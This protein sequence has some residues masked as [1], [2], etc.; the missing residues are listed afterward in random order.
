MHHNLENLRISAS[1]GCRLYQFFSQYVGGY[2]LTRD[3]EIK[4]AGGVLSYRSP[5]AGGG[6]VKTFELFTRGVWS[7]SEPLLGW[8]ESTDVS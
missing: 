1:R 7:F 6:V 2:S 3:A 4:V 8:V 5:T